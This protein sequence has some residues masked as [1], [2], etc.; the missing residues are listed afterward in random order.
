LASAYE[1]LRSLQDEILPMARRA[2]QAA[3]TSFKGGKS[4]YLD[5]LDA[6]RT[7]VDAQSKHVEALAEYHQTRAQVEAL[8][9]QS[10]E[11]VSTKTHSGEDTTNEK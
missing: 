10:I 8:V 5:M 1:E 2:Y 9:G 3:E 11:S 4:G 6:Q 7:L